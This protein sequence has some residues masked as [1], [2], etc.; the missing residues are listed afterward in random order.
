[1]NG[2]GLINALLSA[3]SAVLLVAWYLLAVSGLDVH[4]DNE[5]GRT[6]VVCSVAGC[7][8]ERIHPECHCH[9]HD[10]AGGSCLEGEDCCSDDF[11]A[12]LSI[13]DNCAPVMP[14]LSVPFISL[15][16]LPVISQ[17]VLPERSGPVPGMHSPPPDPAGL[18]RKLCVWR[19]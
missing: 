7:D 15:P 4:R 18:F 13:A 11:R 1:M 6:Y 12:V 17:A 2:K 19:V 5:H 8:C 10:S 16:V 9:D 3:L 14:D